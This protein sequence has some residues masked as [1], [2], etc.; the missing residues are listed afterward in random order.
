[1]A[2]SFPSVLELISLLAIK[3]YSNTLIEK[4]QASA[5]VLSIAC[6]YFYNTNRCAFYW[7]FLV[8]NP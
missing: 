5:L 7:W 6:F 1:M 3:N 4:P 2:R 8:N